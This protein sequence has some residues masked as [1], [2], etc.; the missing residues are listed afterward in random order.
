MPR[1]YPHLWLSALLLGGIVLMLAPR[2]ANPVVSRAEHSRECVVCHIEWGDDYHKLQALLPPPSHR[3]L[4]DGLPARNSTEEMC[5]SCHDGYVA[6]HR[7]SF[8]EDDPHLRALPA[9]FDTGKLPLDLDG[10]VYCGT[11]HTPHSHTM[12]RKYELSPFLRG[13]F[14]GSELCLNCHQDHQGAGH[15]PLHEALAG[16]RGKELASVFAP[17]DRVECLSCHDMHKAHSVKLAEG[18]DLTPL[19]ASCHEGERAVVETR[20]AGFRSA[21]GSCMTCHDVHGG[22]AAAQALQGDAACL[23]CHTAAQGH[24]GGWGHPLGV[25]PAASGG[26]PL[27]QGEVGCASCHDPHRW[28]ADG[29]HDTR[30]PGTAATSFL[31]RADHAEGGLC[32]SCHP[33]QASILES[34]HGATSP[35]FLGRDGSSVWRCSSCHDAHGA[36]VLPTLDGAAGL[37]P[38][39]RLCLTCHGE[40]VHGAAS[41][42]GAFSHPVGAGMGPIRPSWL[43]RGSGDTIGCES[44]HDPHQWSPA[45]ERW[46]AGVPGG[47][48]SSFL[49]QDNHDASLC[50]DCHSDKSSLLGSLHDA[51]RRPEGGTNACAACHTPHRAATSALLSQAVAGEGLDGLLATSDWPADSPEHQ[52]DN[53]SPGALGCLACHHDADSGQRVPEAWFHPT[54]ESGPLPEAVVEHHRDLRIDCRSCHDPHRPWSPEGGHARVQ[55]LTAQSHETL[56]STCHGAEALW[57]YNYYHNPDRRTP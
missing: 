4:I 32:Q 48:R 27:H 44:C 30:E 31:R 1:A 28:S 15:H 7:S 50:L 21:Q 38:A 5:W 11:C 42:V 16:G 29:G 23:R 56:C 14:L 57:R 10:R 55:F 39:T 24:G 19:C 53:W 26:L 9:G 17:G 20:H 22:P 45:G 3:V 46:I 47:D 6:D 41:T 2:K 12:G 13:E 35:A 51:T 34:S 36:G 37:S 52:R 18:R 8:L 54:W 49:R 40:G 33:S 25:P 43:P